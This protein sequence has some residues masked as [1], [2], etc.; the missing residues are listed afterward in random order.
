MGAETALV[1]I[2]AGARGLSI[3]TLGTFATVSGGL[4]GT[5]AALSITDF[6]EIEGAFFA[7]SSAGEN[8]DNTDSFI[9]IG[10]SPMDLLSHHGSGQPMASKI[11]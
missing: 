7:V 2:G 3:A 1:I 6:F 8:E 10:K 5:K 4:E 9:N 11:P